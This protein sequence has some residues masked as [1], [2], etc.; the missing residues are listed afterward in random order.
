VPSPVLWLQYITYDDLM[1]LMD[2]VLK[3]HPGLEFLAETAEFQRKYA[4][5]VVYRIFYTINRCV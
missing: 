4:E 1:P 3:C 2:V 5:T